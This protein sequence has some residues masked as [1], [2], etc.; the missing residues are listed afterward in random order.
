MLTTAAATFLAVSSA[1]VTPVTPVTD[2]VPVG[3]EVVTVNGSGCPA[4]TAETSISGNTFSVSY[5]G[6]FAQAGGGASPVDSRRNCQLSVRTS[7]PPGYTYGLAATSY[8]GFAYLEAGVSAL[9]RVSLYFQGTSSTVAV[10]R[11]FTGPL[12]GEWRSDYRPAE[13]VY[14]P[15]GDSRNL[16]I[17]AELRVAT[18]DPAKRGFLVADAS[19]G[20]LRAKYDF[21]TKR[22]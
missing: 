9:H 18:T 2:E 1:M 20:V 16:N 10:D 7:L 12:A 21:V 22:C 5:R 4:G 13:I 17:N 6:F 8:T 14:S 19:R 15:C 11:P 3:A